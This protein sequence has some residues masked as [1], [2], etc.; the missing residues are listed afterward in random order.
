[1]ERGHSANNLYRK[2]FSLEE[3]CFYENYV[4]EGRVVYL[5]D[6]N[7][8]ANWNGIYKSKPKDFNL[9]NHNM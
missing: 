6:K 1:M 4:F 9:G 2:F 5:L 8:E 3:K 7:G